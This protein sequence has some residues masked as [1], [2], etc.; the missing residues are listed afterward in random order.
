M[1]KKEESS[2]IKGEEALPI[3]IEELIDSAGAGLENTS[4]EDY[5]IPFLVI[6]QQ[7]SPQL[8]KGK[9]EYIKEAE[10][11]DIYNTVTGQLW[12]ANADENGQGV[13]VCPVAF[14]KRLLEWRPRSTGGGL[15][16]I[17]NPEDPIVQHIKRDDR[18]HQFLDNGNVINTTAQYYVVL[19]DYSQAL[20]AMTST[21]LKKSRAWNTMMRNVRLSPPNDHLSPPIYTRMYRLQTV[22]EENDL[23]SWHGWKVKDEGWVVD[24]KLYELAKEFH[25]VIRKGMEISRRSYE[26]AVSTEDDVAPF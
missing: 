2:L 9:A 8:T 11:G 26:E 17:H 14:Q 16:G 20:V 4:T 23:G 7:M 6:L 1:A 19:E 22:H 21:Q 3:P 5:A 10:A 25:N 24:R 15:V 12:K 13:M 18:G